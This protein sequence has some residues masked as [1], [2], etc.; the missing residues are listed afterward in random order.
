[1][2]IKEIYNKIRPKN[3]KQKNLYGLI[4]IVLLGLIVSVVWL[5][6]S[7]TTT[8]K[9]NYHIENVDSIVKITLKDKLGRNIV[10]DRK[11]DS[12]W[13]VNKDYECNQSTMQGFLETF[14]NMRIREDV[15]KAAVNNIVKSLASNGVEVS[16]YTEDYLID[17][18]F[19]HLFKRIHLDR[20]FFVGYETQDRLG[21][22]ML[23]KGDKV[24]RIVHIPEFRG[25]LSSRFNTDPDAWKSHNIFRYKQSEIQ[26]LTIDIP[27]Q[28]SQSFSLKNNG[29]GFDF[30]DFNGQQ[31]NNFD[32]AKVVALL[33]SFVNMNYESVANNINKAQKDTIFT[34]TP[35]Y[36]IT[37][38]DKKG[39]KETM[40]IYLKPGEDEVEI[41]DPRQGFFVAMSDINRCY[42]LTSKTKD[43][44]VMQYFTLDNVLQPASYFIHR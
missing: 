37:I 5:A 27:N 26:Q 32:T 17:F 10:L 11:Q 29:K 2:N 7:K 4:A 16:I 31:I 9:Q 40:T 38:N 6:N 44:L 42:A 30:L 34:H 33:S 21:T 23:K 35:L 24:P 3:R 12:L 28:K 20:T 25:Y 13:V 15:P 39:K 14:A 18:W 8:I 1:M 43:T 36:V 22:Y 19:I 41:E